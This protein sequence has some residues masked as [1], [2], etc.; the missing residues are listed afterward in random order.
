MTPVIE[1]S[2]QSLSLLLWQSVYIEMNTI[3][4]KRAISDINNDD[5]SKLARTFGTQTL[6]AEVCRGRIARVTANSTVT[7]A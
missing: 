3:A 1:K 2:Q 6:S 4:C 7:Y 5:G